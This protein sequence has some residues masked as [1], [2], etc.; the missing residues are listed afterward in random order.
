LFLPLASTWLLAALP[1]LAIVLL[2]SEGITWRIGSHYAAIY[3]PWL[4]LGT[5]AVLVGLARVRSDAAAQRIVTVIFSLCAVV[6]IA[7][8][9]MHVGHYLTP[10][11][12]DLEDA[13]KALAAVPPD[14]N[15]STHDEWYTHIAVEY[16]NA[17]IAWLY[18]PQYAG[19]ADDFNNGS[20]R[21]EVLPKLR[22]GVADGSYRVVAQFGQ[23]KVYKCQTCK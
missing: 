8:N 22:A 18:P 11:Y 9:P 23:V 1:G 13:R 20:F 5:A 7:F 17:T 3:I 15:V 19:F 21:E 16:P 14:A 12:A 6:L 10:P 2:S 4:L